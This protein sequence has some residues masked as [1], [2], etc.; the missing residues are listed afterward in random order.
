MGKGLVYSCMVGARSTILPLKFKEDEVDYIMYT[1]DPKQAKG[2]GWKVVGLPGSKTKAYRAQSR[3]YKWD[4][5]QLPDGYDWVLWV[6]ST[7]VPAI[8]LKKIV[9]EE[10]LRICGIA[11][12]PHPIRKCSYLEIDACGKRGKDSKVVLDKSRE[13][14]RRMKASEASGLYALGL[15][16]RR[17]CDKQRKLGSDF[18]N[19]LL[20]LC[21][22]DQIFFVPFLEKHGINCHGITP[23]SVY[24]SEFFTYYGPHG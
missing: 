23:G 2:K 20:N 14:L 18:L 11:A 7:H 12:F 4:M 22:R 17:V 19:P 8:P 15:V 10:W 1:D 24:S 3:I 9:E 6:D 5:A 13:Y 16:A 21:P